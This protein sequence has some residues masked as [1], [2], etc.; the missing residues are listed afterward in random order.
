MVS[1][2][3]VLG[4]TPLVVLYI[5]S[6]QFVNRGIDD[7]FNVDVE[8]GLGNAL[9]LGQTALE[10]QRRE[11]LAKLQQIAGR[12]RAGDPAALITNLSDLRQESGAEELT[13]FSANN[14]IIATISDDPP[15]TALTLPSVPSYPADEVLIQLR[16]GL[17]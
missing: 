3:V 2:V 1:L 17:P 6:V 7:W 11:D 4:V 14:Q 15:G 12:L 5:F 13:L 9:A 16:Q 8:A 10:L